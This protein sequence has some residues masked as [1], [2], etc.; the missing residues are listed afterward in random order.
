ML[1]GPPADQS[2]HRPPARAFPPSNVCEYSPMAQQ[3]STAFFDSAQEG[4]FSVPLRGYDRAQVDA[5]VQRVTAALAAA[6]QARAEAEQ[7]LAEGQ[8]RLRQSEQRLT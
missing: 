7:R 4:D 6:E 3:S 2:G 8:R 5:Y 1:A